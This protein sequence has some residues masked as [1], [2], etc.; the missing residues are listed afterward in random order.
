MNNEDLFL[1]HYGVPGMRWY[2]RRRRREEAREAKRVRT[3]ESLRSKDPTIDKKI[4]YAA[5]LSGK[6]STNRI[7][8]IIGKQP[9]R[10]FASAEAQYLGE[11]IATA[12]LLYAGSQGISKLM[13]R[14]MGL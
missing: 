1:Q 10:S 4:K 6:K 9:S 14:R 11:S 8:D 3:L 2:H 13:L 5:R 7:L 12:F